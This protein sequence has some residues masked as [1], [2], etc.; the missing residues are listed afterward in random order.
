[1]RDR[2]VNP[3]IDAAIGMA[4]DSTTAARPPWTIAPILFR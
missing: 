3:D 2:C 4:E 1:M